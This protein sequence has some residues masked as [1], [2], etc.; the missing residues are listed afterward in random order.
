MRTTLHEAATQGDIGAVKALLAEHADVNAKGRGGWTPLHLAAEKG[1]KGIVEILLANGAGVDPVT[2][3]GATPLIIAAVQGQTAVASV[4]ITKGADANAKANFGWTA[5]QEAASFNHTEMAE[6]LLARHAD[7]NAEN[8]FGWTPLHYAA[9]KGNLRLVQKLIDSGGDI[10]A[11]HAVPEW[12]D[13]ESQEWK[14]KR[15]EIGMTPLFFAARHGHKEVTELLTRREKEVQSDKSK[16]AYSLGNP[17]P[18]GG[19]VFYLD[20]SGLHGL[21][22]N[23]EDSGSVAWSEASNALARTG[24]GR[25]PTVRELQLLLK[26]KDMVG[27]FKEGCY[28]SSEKC[29]GDSILCWSVVARFGNPYE[30]RG[31]H[32]SHKGID[33]AYV[34]GIHDF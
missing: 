27:G 7:V 9:E 13:Y 14:R 15:R 30:L 16:G 23:R 19:I 17:G 12:R 2:E 34:R 8:E 24:G 6:L 31:F 1:H 21:E 20:E 32:D 26:R 5:L 25:L 4:L 28:W 11:A 10:Y 18:S 3:F 29:P 22:A 33:G